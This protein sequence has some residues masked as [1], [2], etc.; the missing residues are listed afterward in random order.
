MRWP[1][2]PASRTR[3]RR[4]FMTQERGLMRLLTR[5][6]AVSVVAVLS[7]GVI[8]AASAAPRATTI[9]VT[10]TD[11]AIKL[12]KKTETV[13]AVSFAVKNTGKAAHNFRIAGKQTATLKH[14][15]TAKL[16][17]TFSKAGAYAYSSTVKGD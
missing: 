15:Q 9:N 13:G 3:K 1:R 8:A 16:A 14:N 7:L 5:V 4:P 12:S 2:S 10:I 17:V 6:V 11:K